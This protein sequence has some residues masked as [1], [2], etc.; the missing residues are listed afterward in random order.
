MIGSEKRVYFE[1]P[2]VVARLAELRYEV[3]FSTAGSRQ[4]VTGID[5]DAQDFVFP[6][7][8]LRNQLGDLPGLDND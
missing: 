8:A 7:S 2:D 4:I 3:K 6:S 1:D 5:I